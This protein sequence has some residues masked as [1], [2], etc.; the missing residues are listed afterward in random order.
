[1]LLSRKF[2]L[3]ALTLGAALL[4][5]PVRAAE[6]DN[7]TPADAQAVMVFNVK[8]ALNSPLAKKKGAADLIKNGIDGNEHAKQTL[9]AL[10]LDP[11]KDIDSVSIAVG[12]ITDLQDG[13]KPEKMLITIHGSFDPERIDAAAKKEGVKVSKEGDVTVYEFKDKE[14]GK[15]EPGYATLIGKS[16]VAASPSKEYLLKS[17][18]SSGSASKDLVKA[19]AKIEAK[20]SIWM[21]VVITDDMRKKMA[22]NPQFKALAAKLESVTASVDVSDAI[23]F[24][25]NVNTTDADA[26]KMIKTQIDAFLP[27]IR[28]TAEA[29]EKNGE[30]AKE[31][32]SNL[33]IVANPNGL[34]VNLKISETTLDKIIKLASGAK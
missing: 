30:L 34:N 28:T 10:G 22:E 26:A 1:M 16:V 7:L 15:D 12:A 32:F 13:K 23:V 3:T 5:A 20:Q 19:S 17:I 9:A 8:Q 29:D 31:L 2:T 24:D 21:A 33:K 18:K 25:L 27:F 6:L 14:K 4:A 11:T